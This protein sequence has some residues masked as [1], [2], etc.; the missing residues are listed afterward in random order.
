MLSNSLLSLSLTF[1]CSSSFS[2]AGSGLTYWI[3]CVDFAAAL[4]SMKLMTEKE[5]ARI[6]KILW[7]WGYRADVTFSY[8]KSCSG[9]GSDYLKLI[10][11]V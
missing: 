11:L 7:Y 2:Q 5:K 1:I 4:S 9:E 3:L 8:W 6:E 10:L